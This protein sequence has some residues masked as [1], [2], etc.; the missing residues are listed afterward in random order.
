M[1]AQIT[2]AIASA[3]KNANR[4]IYEWTQ[5]CKRATFIDK[6]SALDTNAI[7]RNWLVRELKN[8]PF[9]GNLSYFLKRVKISFE[10]DRNHNII[11]VNF[12]V[13]AAYSNE[14]TKLAEHLKEANKKNLTYS[15]VDK[16]DFSRIERINFKS[17]IN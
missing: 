8:I 4:N 3:I 15:F 10:T 12:D 9:K 5:E 14:Y 11:N 16:V 17:P 6:P 2:E 7:L 1:N 13:P